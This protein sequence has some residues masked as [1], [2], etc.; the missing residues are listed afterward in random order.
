VSGQPQA[1]VP[2][3][4]QSWNVLTSLPMMYSLVAGEEL[5]IMADER[6]DILVLT[7][8]LMTSNRTGDFR[9]RHPDRFYNLG[10][11]E[12]NMFSVAAGLAT[13]GYT[14]Y[15]STFASFAALLCAEHVRTDLAYPGLPVRILAHHAGVSMGFYGTSH[16]ATEDIALMRA[17]PGLTVVS[18]SDASALRALLRATID[19]PGPVYLRLGRGRERPVH[20]DDVTLLPGRMHRLRDG[21]DLTIIGTGLGT[22]AAVEAAALLS[23]E[24][25]EARVL[26]A[27]WLKPLDADQVV[28]SARETGAIL[29]VEEHSTVGGL[30]GAV[31]EI[32]CDAGEAV[33]FVRHGMPDDY[34]L[35]APPTHLYR[36]YGL[37]GEGVA[38]RARDLLDTRPAGDRATGP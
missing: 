14:P 36:H 11:A 32:L 17:I 13:C 31:S 6:E 27:L 8:D 35:V 15:V 16:H 38:A 5:A 19:T 33:P 3:D 24:G 34:A 25:I 29:T 9:D 18:A 23:Q 28:D 37:T 4:E 2:L 1:D 21:R 30:G 22:Y 7:A 26:D 12:Q 10:I 20:D